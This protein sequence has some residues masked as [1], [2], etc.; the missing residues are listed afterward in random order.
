MSSARL[1][2]VTTLAIFARVVETKSFTAAAALLG[3]TKAMV[4]QRI[5]ALERQCAARLIERTTRRLSLT[6]DGEALYRACAGLTVAADG[7]AAM[8]GHVG[9][10]PQ[11]VL[12]VTVPVGLGV[13][14]LIPTLPAFSARY[15]EVA[16]DLEL[17]DRIVDPAAD[18]FDVAVRFARRLAD[19]SLGSRKLATEEYT[20]V[21]A[22]PAYLAARGPPEMPDDLRRHLCL[23]LTPVHAEWSFYIADERVSVPVTGPLRCNDV[24]ALREAAVAGLGIAMLPR[25]LVKDDLERGRVVAVLHGFMP[26]PSSLWALFPSRHVPAKSRVFVEH[27]ASA[28]KSRRDA[29][30]RNEAK[31]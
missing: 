4:S 23:R 30:V 10:V 21:C 17:T 31:R 18:G 2:E 3:V 14:E 13:S 7:A 24:R 25:S 9:R 28:L 22:A 29:R 15:P 12:R 11:G 1:Q 16:L 26:P 20:V 19:S 6:A 8:I 27:L 5:T